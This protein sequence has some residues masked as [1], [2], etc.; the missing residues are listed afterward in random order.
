MRTNN[1]FKVLAASIIV[2]GMSSCKNSDIEFPDYAEQTVYFAYQTPIRTLVLGMNDNGSTE[3]NDKRACKIYATMG[4]AYDGSKYNIKV[5]I[6]EDNSLCENLYFDAACTD[7]VLPM[8]SSHYQLGGNV[9]QYQG[10]KGYVDVTFTDAFFADPKSFN[11]KYVIPIVM[12][13]QTGATRILSGQLQ[14]GITSANRFDLD[15]W[16]V[17][18][19]DY[20]LYCVRYISKFEGYYLPQGTV[21]TTY[22]GK[23]ETKN[24]NVEAWERVP[25]GNILFL[26]TRGENTV[27]LNLVA[28]A[29]G[30]S[31]TIEAL[32]TF[33]GNNCTVTSS[34]SRF[35]VSGSGV[36]TEKSPDY[37]WGQKDRD[38][39]K[40]QIKAEGNG[41]IMDCDYNMA[42]QRRGSGNTV[43]EFSVT[44]KK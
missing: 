2:L 44:L 5:D 15:S 13:S 38:G 3:D 26:D 18:P 28:A 39:L 11:G 12:K 10:E 24:L 22:D 30:Q 43:E 20:V 9:I 8:P 29:G 23:T 6:S 1:I 34:D 4:G 31:Y 33:N 40:L 14:E 17:Q 37:N 36:Y 19:Q 7:P 16:F 21:N 32:L 25:Q 41:I 42:L 35:K 27:A